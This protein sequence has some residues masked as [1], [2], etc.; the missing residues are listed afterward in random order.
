MF[1]ISEAF[2][3][4]QEE[5][6]REAEG[7]SGD[8]SFFTRSKNILS[9]SSVWSEERRLLRWRLLRHAASLLPQE[10][11]STCHKRLGFGSSGVVLEVQGESARYRGLFKCDSVY[12]CPVCSSRIS[13]VRRSELKQ[14]IQNH[15]GPVWLLTL[16]MRHHAGENTEETLTALKAAVRRFKQYHTW[17]ELPLVG[18]VSSTEI[19]YGGAGPHPHL[20]M[21]LFLEAGEA[22]YSPQSWNIV[23]LSGAWKR[24]LSAEGRS[25]LDAVGLDL[26]DGSAASSYVS[27][28]GSDAELA[29]SQMKSGRGSLT[30]WELLGVSLLSDD[31]SVS[32]KASSLF[33]EYYFAFKGRKQL[34]W[35]PNL[36]NIL[37]SN[38]A[39]TEEDCRSVSMPISFEA[40]R[41]LWLWSLLG[42]LLVWSSSGE[43]ERVREKIDE[44]EKYSLY[45]KEKR[46]RIKFNYLDGGASLTSMDSS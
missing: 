23:S 1:E 26:R 20:H 27:K 11:V 46:L 30:P 35:S 12:S 24:A 41:V 39:E 18:H 2:T 8:A 29:C 19:T 9:N 16:T 15:K 5:K 37:L 13:G 7:L 31:S 40:W 42:H 43:I 25:C 21:L 34:T 14:A 10:K 33:K 28:W 6:N 38:D 45:L 4:R 17:R 32:K 22:D 44:A 3:V 36:K